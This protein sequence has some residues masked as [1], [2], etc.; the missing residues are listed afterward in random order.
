M[1]KRPAEE[2][3]PSATAPPPI[4]RG[5][6]ERDNLDMA[7]KDNEI[8]DGRL[9]SIEM[10]LMYMEDFIKQLQEVTVGHSEE[11]DSL[12]KEAKMMSEKIREMS[13]LL[14]GDI[15]NRKPPHY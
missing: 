8:V 3:A 13:D 12:H 5:Q 1:R 10:K 11:L 6:P 9:T 15:P 7:D 14:E 2:E 4:D